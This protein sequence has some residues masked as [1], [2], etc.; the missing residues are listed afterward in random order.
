MALM[1]FLC[2]RP[3]YSGPIDTLAVVPFKL[4]GNFQDAEIYSHG[5]PDAIAHDISQIPDL[6]VAERLHLSS[7]LQELNFTQTGLMIE[8]EMDKIGRLLSANIIIVGSV[9]KM[10]RDA[11]VQVR[12]I[13]VTTGEVIL[14]VKENSKIRRFKNVLDLENRI[15]NQIAVHL[16]PQWSPGVSTGKP[17]YPT[18]HK[19]AFHHYSRGLQ[20]LDKGEYKNGFIAFEK[21]ID[22]DQKFEWAKEV[23]SR[24]QKVF[25][26]L[27][28]EAE[29]MEKK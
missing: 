25:E 6:T 29:K 17:K 20:Y 27:E 7:V 19:D 5:L 9:Q 4:I 12:L 14:A 18:S 13:R 11:L 1:L 22:I 23:Q 24:A 2:N 21:A 28:R 16:C 10:K 8:D 3:S 15:S 26:E